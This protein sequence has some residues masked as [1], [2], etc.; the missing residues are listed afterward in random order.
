MLLNYTYY[1]FHTSNAHIVE[2][3]KV[4][5]ITVIDVCNELLVINLE[6]V[7]IKVSRRDF[8]GSYLDRFQIMPHS[9][10]LFSGPLA[11]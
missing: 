11:A 7:N 5:N 4:Y 10:H 6:L 8:S 9:I 3:I 2:L 1:G